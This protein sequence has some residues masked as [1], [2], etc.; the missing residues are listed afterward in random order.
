MKKLLFAAFPLAAFAMVMN[1]AIDPLPIGAS[2]PNAETKMKSVD[3]KD[4]S[5]NDLKTG[6]GL[7]VMFSCNTCPYVEKNQERT[8]AICKFAKDNGIGIAIINSNEAYRDGDDS[9]DAMKEYAK[10]QE[11][12]WPYLVDQNS[13]VADAFGATRTPECFLF[14]GN[15]KLVYTG[16]IDDSPGDKNKVERTHLKMA[17]EEMKSGKDVSVKQS[18]S[19]GCT[20]K[21]N[22]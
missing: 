5:L 3:G 1:T 18:K 21:R 11:Y 20:I 17:I 9:Y 10:K 2:I 4:L 19:V 15:G 7:L 22:K 14:D 6:K 12:K 13:T 16:A 8:N